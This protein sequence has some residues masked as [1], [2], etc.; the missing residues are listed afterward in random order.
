[1]R[2][3]YYTDL[4]ITIYGS[5]NFA[6]SNFKQQSAP[7]LVRTK[8]SKTITIAHTE[9]HMTQKTFVVFC[10]L[11]VISDA[12]KLHRQLLSVWSICIFFLF[13]SWVIDFTCKFCNFV[14]SIFLLFWMFL[15]YISKK[16]FVSHHNF[17][18]LQRKVRSNC[19][20]AWRCG[21]SSHIRDDVL[22]YDC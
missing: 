6:R 5:R 9:L 10:P 21:F 11:Q 14:R 2:S 3:V 15:T 1:M 16:I 12:L 18:P 13:L 20:K 22:G 4:S 8:F 19:A 7:H 17:C